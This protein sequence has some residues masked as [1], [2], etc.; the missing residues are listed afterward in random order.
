MGKNI[1]VRDNDE[2]KDCKEII[3]MGGGNVAFGLE[4]L[5]QKEWK[6]LNSKGVRSFS[7]TTLT[8]CVQLFWQL[9]K[10]T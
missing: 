9:G 2:W 4:R 8:N 3:A 5:I 7:G 10:K 6:R 1:C